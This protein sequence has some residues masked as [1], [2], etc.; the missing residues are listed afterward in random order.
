MA[1]KKHIYLL[2]IGGIGMSALARYYNRNGYT[3]SGY[4][5]TRTELTKKLETEGIEIHYTEDV[6]KIPENPELIIYTPAVPKEHKEIQW[7]Q[8]RGCELKKRAEV[9]GIISREKRALAVAGTHGKT[10]TT[11]LLTHILK[12][13]GIDCTAFLGGIAENYGSNFVAGSSDFVVVEADE[14]DRSFLHLSPE[15]AA[16]TS[17][18]AD[19]LDIYGDADTMLESGFGAFVKKVNPEGFVFLQ[20]DAEVKSGHPQ[21][22]RYG[23]NRGDYR[24]ENIRV[25][26]GWF[27][28]DFKSE[29]E[30]I[31]DIKIALPGRHN[32]EN[33]TAA[34]AVA[35]QVG[36]TGEAVKEALRTFKG[37]KR[38]FEFLHRT[39]NSVYIDD[40]AHH[41]SELKAAIGAARELFPDKKITGIFQPHLYSRTQDFQDGFAAELSKLDE[42]ILLDIYPARELPIPGVTSKIVFDKIENKRKKLMRKE[43]VSKELKTRKTEVVM[44]LGAGDIDTLRDEI[45]ALMSKGV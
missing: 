41:P 39:K 30:N 32:I 37:I 24:A 6:T 44:T 5:K 35:Q 20:N 3:V 12:V 34:I 4:D 9:L 38:R 11:S 40:Y 14:Y 16:V 18:D 45:K 33:A 10:T 13:G 28:F 7:L 29:I 31:N 42:V 25:E 8:K 26:D 21:T 22:F 17:T 1:N 36:V 27:T 15:I 19:H 2:G 43:E 23:I